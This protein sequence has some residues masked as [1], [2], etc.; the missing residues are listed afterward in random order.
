MQKII[1]PDSWNFGE[2]VVQQIP[3]SSRG[4]VGNDFNGFVKRAGY[5]FANKIASMDIPEGCIPLHLIAMGA[6]EA[7]GP[8]R[9]GDGFREETLKAAHPTFVKYAKFYRDHKNTDPSKSYGVVKLSHYNEDMKRVELLALLNGNE[10]VA[11]EHGGFVADKEIDRLSRSGNDLPVSMAVK[12]AYDVCVGCGNKARTPKEYCTENNCKMGGCRNN[13]MTMTD[14]GL[15]YVDNPLPCRFMDISHV[16]RGADP[17]AFAHV[18]NYLEKCA[19]GQVMGGAALAEAW[20][21]DVGDDVPWSFGK[22]DP[23][24]K[25]ARRVDQL[26]RMMYHD[27][28]R[29]KVQ[30][31]ARAFDSRVLE[32]LSRDDIGTPGSIKFAHTIQ[33]LRKHNIMLTLPEYIR[34]YDSEESEDLNEFTQ[35]VAECLPGV[36]GRMV[37]DGTLIEYLDENLRHT[38]CSLGSTGYDRWAEGLQAGRSLSTEHIGTRLKYATLRGVQP[39][40]VTSEKRASVIERDSIYDQVAKSY[41]AHQLVVMSQMPAD[42]EGMPL[43]AGAVILQNLGN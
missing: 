19:S 25:L 12:I 30:N 31:L 40:L 9:N 37:E 42:T 36:F 38:S 24:V 28:N 18:A 14:S 17:T 2:P 34:Q 10:K 23:F 20:R 22:Y 33:A 32:P 13:L 5:S 39:K 8:N 4:L 7:V 29:E 11:K 41:A 26:E 16:K 35:K 21:L 27:V 15:L 6:T 43:T 1:S 3:I